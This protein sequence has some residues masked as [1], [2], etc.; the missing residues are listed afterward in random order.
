MPGIKMQ[1]KNKLRLLHS[2]ITLLNTN[3]LNTVTT[4]TMLHTEHTYHLL[5][6]NLQKIKVYY[7]NNKKKSKVLEGKLKG[8]NYEQCNAL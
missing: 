7:C 4:P 3:S 8:V 6:Y 2:N 5:Y 1:H